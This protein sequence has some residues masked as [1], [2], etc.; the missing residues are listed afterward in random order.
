MCG[1][2][3]NDAVI[4]LNYPLVDVTGVW[5]MKSYLGNHN[6]FASREVRLYQSNTALDAAETETKRKV[7]DREHKLDTSRPI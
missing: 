7:S 4:F 3:P 6:C 5:D 1:F 2:S